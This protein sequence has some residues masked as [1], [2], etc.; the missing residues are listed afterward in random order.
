VALGVDE[1][2][3]YSEN[4]KTGLAEGQ[5]IVLGTDGIWEAHNPKGEMFGKDR[6][7]DVIR[8]NSTVSAKKIVDAI[9]DT[10]QRFQKDQEPEDDV[11]LVVIKIDGEVE[12]PDEN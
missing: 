1:Y 3:Q 12:K 5:I 9:I 7:N 4:M 6:L 10:L 2:W 11:T 8:R